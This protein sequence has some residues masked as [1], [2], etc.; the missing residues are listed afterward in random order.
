MWERWCNSTSMTKSANTSVVKVRDLASSEMEACTRAWP[1]DI[2]SARR[3]AKSADHLTSM[4]DLQ[5][6]PIFWGG[7]R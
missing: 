7:D 3:L 1:P 5:E 2:K 4:M 6:G